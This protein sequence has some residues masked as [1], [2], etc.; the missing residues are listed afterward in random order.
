MKKKFYKEDVYDFLDGIQPIKSTPWR[1]GHI[2]T[3]V[4]K[5]AEEYYRVIIEVSLSD[6]RQIHSNE[7]ECERVVPIERTVTDYIPYKDNLE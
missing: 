1:H 3:Y 7:I 2:D 5:C 4:F 6:G